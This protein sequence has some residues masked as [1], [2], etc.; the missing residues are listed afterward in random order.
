ME[1][2]PYQEYFYIEIPVAAG[3]SLPGVPSSTGTAT[4]T[5]SSSAEGAGSD[6]ESSSSSAVVSHLSSSNSNS[7][8]VE[9]GKHRRFVYVQEE[10]AKKFPMQFGLEVILYLRV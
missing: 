10:S 6:A 2:G 7:S 3:S 5:D 4:A 1:G 9:K 8:R